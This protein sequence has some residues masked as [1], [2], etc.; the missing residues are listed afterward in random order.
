MSRADFDFK[1]CDMWQKLIENEEK[2][3]THLLVNLSM[4]LKIKNKKNRGPRIY[5]LM[6]FAKLLIYKYLMMRK[7]FM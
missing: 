5:F 4:E 1:N 2:K 3:A 6:K 7:R